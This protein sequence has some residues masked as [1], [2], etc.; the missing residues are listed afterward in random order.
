MFC[1]ASKSAIAANTSTENGTD[2]QADHNIDS[3]SIVDI[4]FV[5]DN[6]T[7]TGTDIQADDTKHT[8]SDARTDSSSIDAST[9]NVCTA[10][11]PRLRRSH[12][13]EQLR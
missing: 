12:A 4:C 5:T 2:I 6:N 7:G 9:A 13:L 3:S 8:S 1:I 11:M 10:C